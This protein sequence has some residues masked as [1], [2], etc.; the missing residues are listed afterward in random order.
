MLSFAYPAMKSNRRP[1]KKAGEAQIGA[2]DS[3]LMG[4]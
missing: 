4:D 3:W 2:T 1:E